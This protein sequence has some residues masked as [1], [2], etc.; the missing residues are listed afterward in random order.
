MAMEL[1]FSESTLG[2]RFSHT[3]IFLRHFIEQWLLLQDVQLKNLDEYWNLEK[4]GG[5]WLNQI[6]EL[7]TLARPL[8]LIG[9]QFILDI[10][11]LDDPS[12]FLDGEVGEILDNMYRYLIQLRNVGVNKLF[13]MKNISELMEL[14]FG[15]QNIEVQFRENVDIVG[16]PREHYFQILLTFKKSEDY[17]IFVGIAETNPTLFFGK[18]MGVSYDIYCEWN[19]DL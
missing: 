4:A 2:W 18:A 10:D 9:N 16:R 17:R 15:A 7:F 3:V 6:G 11:H 14:V 5:V 12:V 1:T 8:G 13:C 19:P